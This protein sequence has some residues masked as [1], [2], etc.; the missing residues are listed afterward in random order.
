MGVTKRLASNI[1]VP[2][3]TYRNSQIIKNLLQNHS[4]FFACT[5]KDRIHERR[6][7]C[8]SNKNT[9]GAGNNAARRTPRTDLE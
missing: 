2:A 5:L 1:P 8:R 6:S 9:N 4:V 7:N 3:T